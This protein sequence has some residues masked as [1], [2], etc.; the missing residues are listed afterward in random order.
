ME[1]LK[2][3]VRHLRHATLHLP[4][5]GVHVQVGDLCIFFLLFLLSLFLFSLGKLLQAV[6]HDLN[7]VKWHPLDL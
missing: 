4:H 3:E 2:F 6:K 1:K 7:L 5:H